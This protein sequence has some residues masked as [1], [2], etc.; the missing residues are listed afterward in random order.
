LTPET[1]ERLKAFRDLLIRWNATINLVSRRDLPVLWE[2]HITDS[3][4]LTA[5]AD[6]VP[7]R[8]I[9]LGSGGGFPGLVLAIATGAHVHL[10]EEDQR[11]C[12]FLREAARITAAP[13]SVHAARIEAVSIPPAP[14]VTARALAPIARL[15]ALAEPKLVPGGACWFLKGREAEA[16]LAAAARDWAMTV[17]RRPSVTDP[18]GVVLRLS[19]IRRQRAP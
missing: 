13:V 5:L 12:A 10:I 9:D 17:E 1:R 3:L 4:Q 6:P 18:A 14:V 7:E 15:L 16:E 8:I 2:R 19:G 11:K